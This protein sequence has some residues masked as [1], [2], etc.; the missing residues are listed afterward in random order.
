MHDLAASLVH[1]GGDGSS[2]QRGRD[3]M[4]LKVMITPLEKMRAARLVRA[5]CST[6]GEKLD[7][8]SRGVT[9]Q[10]QAV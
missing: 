6:F 7:H 10:S 9:A 4:G 3:C 5:G 2:A 1:S 8:V